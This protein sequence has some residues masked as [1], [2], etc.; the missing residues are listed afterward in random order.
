MAMLID[1]RKAREDGRE[2]EYAFGFPP[3]LDRTLVISKDSL[4]ARPADG[5]TDGQ[6]ERVL[7]KIMQYQ[8]AEGSWP[9]A[10]SYAA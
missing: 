3:A 1:F 6:Y 2:V 10:G 5:R 9:E 8:D 7:W 4:T